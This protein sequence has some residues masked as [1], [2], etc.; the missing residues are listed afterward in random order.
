MED[1][2]KNKN[3]EAPSKV[4]EP[5]KSEPVKVEKKKEV[6]KDTH[7]AEVEVEKPKPIKDASKPERTIKKVRRYK[8]RIGIHSGK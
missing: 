3:A 1:G 6:K 5:A 4:G 8:S 2:Q 7:L